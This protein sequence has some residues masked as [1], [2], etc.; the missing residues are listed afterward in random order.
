MHQALED[1]NGRREGRRKRWR[2]PARRLGRKRKSIDRVENLN[3]NAQEWL[4]IITESQK[5]NERV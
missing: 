1:V 4:E 5:L 3:S 2:G